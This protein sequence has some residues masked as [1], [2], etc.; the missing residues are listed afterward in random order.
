[1]KSKI[2]VNVTGNN[3]TDMKM[4]ASVDAAVEALLLWT[5]QCTQY[6]HIIILFED[7]EA[8]TAEKVSFRSV[9]SLLS[10]SLRE[11]PISAVIAIPPGVDEYTLSSVPN[12]YWMC[13][14]RRFFSF[15]N[16][17]R[18]FDRIVEGVMIGTK[19]PITMGKKVF[20]VWCE[21]FREHGSVK[22]AMVHLK[23]ALRLHFQEE[24]ET[25][26]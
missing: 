21:A 14:R 22:E 24:G 20:R 3:K 2:A 13:V 19:L 23:N 16:P 5:G 10:S 9:I 7:A 26:E 25:Y 17:F 1:M 4:K 15:P 11:I 6:D 18:I 12:S 8:F